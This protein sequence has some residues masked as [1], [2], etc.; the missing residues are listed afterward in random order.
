MTQSQ[1]FRQVPARLEPDSAKYEY[2]LYVVCFH[3]FVKVYAE[4][5]TTSP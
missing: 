1:H 2:L 3:G 4:A 5:A